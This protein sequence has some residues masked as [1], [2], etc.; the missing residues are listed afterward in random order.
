MGTGGAACCTTVE[1]SEVPTSLVKMY[2]LAST[3]QSAKLRA[4]LRC[5]LLS[6]LLLSDV[7]EQTIQA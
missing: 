1:E 2:Q 4:K 5:L 7:A 6:C 3:S